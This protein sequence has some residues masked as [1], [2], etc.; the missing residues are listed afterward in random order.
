MNDRK[1][2]NGENELSS[3]GV[4]LKKTKQEPESLSDGVRS[5]LKPCTKFF[6][7]V[8]CPLGE[9]CH[10][11]HDIHGGY[12][13]VAQMMNLSPSISPVRKT[14]TTASIADSSTPRTKTRM[15][16]NYNT[17][18]GCKYG[19]KCRFSHGER[20]LTGERLPR[21]MDAKPPAGPASGFGA[22]ATT[23]ISIEASLAGIVIGKGGMN[24]CLICRGTGVKLRVRDHDRDPTLKNVELKGTFEQISEASAMV[25][26]LISARAWPERNFKAKMCKNFAKGACSFG[27]RCH[28]AHGESELRKRL[29]T[30]K[31]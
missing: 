10:F 19:N 24:S 4:S 2:D 23:K 27:E 16:A 21:R 30:V 5:N 13:A 31:R 17:A 1:R 6:S 9:N 26:E 25:K 7:T 20:Q 12:D 8:G 3:H 15:C 11:Q 14:A 28:F 22:S 18:E 29:G